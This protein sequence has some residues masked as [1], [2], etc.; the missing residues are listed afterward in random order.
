MWRIYS[1]DSESICVRTTVGRL[2]DSHCAANKVESSDSCF[3]G[4]VDYPTDFKLLKFF[5]H[6]VFKDSLT[7]EAVARS[8]L[9]KR[10]AFE[11]EDEVR[12]IYFEGKNMRYYKGVYE[13]ELDPHAVFDQFMIDPRMSYKGFW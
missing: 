13:Y 1:P 8:L 5:A 11:H 6:T 2:I 3:I 4:K 7:T 12:L 10:D 9:K